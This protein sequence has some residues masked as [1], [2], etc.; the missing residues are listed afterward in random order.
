MRLL[1]IDEAADRL[2]IH[3]STLRRLIADG[4]ISSV[5]PSRGCVRV[6]EVD[7]DTMI[8]SRSEDVPVSAQS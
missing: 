8:R 7:V 1:R 3:P 4:K 6:R 5:R 2:S